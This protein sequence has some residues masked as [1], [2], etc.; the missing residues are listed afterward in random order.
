MASVR[1]IFE[2]KPEELI[3]RKVIGPFGNSEPVQIVR[4]E[5]LLGDPAKVK[6][7]AINPETHQFF[8]PV[9][10]IQKLE[11]IEF[12]T[13]FNFSGDPQRFF[14]IMMGNAI[15]SNFNQDPLF[16]VGSSKID[17]L[18]HQLE[19]VY[20]YILPRPRTRFMIADEPGAGKTIMAGLVIKELLARGAV[21]RI[22]IVV[23]GS[24]TGQ[25][26]L[27][28]K[29][30][31]NEDFVI[32][33]SDFLRSLGPRAWIQFEK[34]ITSMDFAKNEVQ[35]KRQKGMS[36]IRNSLLGVPWDI[37][38]VDEAHKMS[39]EW[40]M[41]QMRERTTK[42]YQLGKALSEQTDHLLFLTAT[43]H[44][45]KSDNFRLLLKLLESDSF[46]EGNM[47]I[48]PVLKEFQDEEYPIFIRR[49]KEEMVTPEGYPIFPPRK[50]K[51]I[52][53][54]LSPLESI[55]YKN[56]TEYVKNT[57]NLAKAV[58]GRRGSSIGFM[59]KLLQR[60]LNSSVRAIHRTLIHRKERLEEI[61][62]NP[63][64]DKSI[65]ELRS[66]IE[67]LSLEVEEAEL[68]DDISPRKVEAIHKEI[69][70][71]TMASNPAELEMEIETLGML[72]QA[73][74]EAET[75]QCESKL[76]ALL[77]EIERNLGEQ[78]LIIFTEYTDTL[79]YLMERIPDVFAKGTIHGGMDYSL[80][81]GEQEKFWNKKIQIL[82]CTD[83]ASE[84]INLQCCWNLINYDIPWNPNRLDQR[85][86]RIHRYLQDHKCTFFNLVATET[87]DGDSIAEGLVVERIF[88]K[89][90]IMREELGGTDRVFDV[91][92][93]IFE[94]WNF[95]QLLVQSLK[96]EPIDFSA[97]VSK[98]ESKKIQKLLELRAN[99]DVGLEFFV[100]Q[101]TESEDN[102]LWP[103]YIAEY[104][105]SGFWYA[106]RPVQFVGDGPFKIQVPPKILAQVKKNVQKFGTIKHNLEITFYKPTE[107][108][109]ME[110]AQECDYVTAG[111]PLLE[112]IIDIAD[113]KGQDAIQQGTIFLDPSHGLH[114]LLWFIEIIFTDGTCSKEILRRT[115][116]LFTPFI[117]SNETINE[118]ISYQI[119]SPLI[120]WDLRRDFSAGTLVQ[121]APYKAFFEHSRQ[122]VVEGIGSQLCI[123]DELELKNW[124]EK[125]KKIK[126]KA[127]ERR[128]IRERVRLEAGISLLLDKEA[129][130][131]D[132]EQ[133][134]LEK[135]ADR[136]NITETIQELKRSIDLECTV[137]RQSPRL[138]SIA[139]VVPAHDDGQPATDIEEATQLADTHAIDVAAMKA[140]IAYEKERGW[141]VKDKSKIKCG[142]DIESV[143]HRDPTEIRHIEVKGHKGE[144]DVFISKN[145]WMKAQNDVSGNYWLYIVNKAL[146]KP[147]VIPISDPASKFEP[148]RII[149]EKF[150]IPLKQIREFY[151]N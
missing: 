57:F 46:D 147:Q 131:E 123:E 12:V 99:V 65:K 39:A 146:E 148:E 25:W 102:R 128:E 40:D 92:G 104:V 44:K 95:E 129:D 16:A 6:F 75:E 33:D 137:I 58:G 72:I 70:C 130:G 36:F 49:L 23:P 47:D 106:N 55:L 134:I 81:A 114:G 124:R 94:E 28:L 143:N 96:V 52:S 53:F 122:F 14:M 136:D 74:A 120:L 145:E 76:N 15:R 30:R 54:S 18:P 135:E 127:L 66:R 45:G 56:V 139:I 50:A 110:N 86:G 69:F 79:D 17:P 116:V 80:R 24:L 13:E 67:K 11:T 34:I 142:Y 140:V 100:Q 98:A 61:L 1:E 125:T 77:G 115:V 149:T 117:D 22:L 4:V 108:Q 35:K 59:L 121:L 82:V 112:A 20:K 2:Q 151:N 88:E 78:Q 42:R 38:V 71:L 9:L 26:R 83:A 64:F 32:L 132:V 43:P 109:L 87:S 93:D 60:R 29:N 111:H 63:D 141:K 144:E 41:R 84:G 5:R 21:K 126:I 133:K 118:K 7:I 27:E 8:D 85:M 48:L 97:Q 90:E 113:K 73:A 91:I 105:R 119:L 3:N 103:K 107:R 150:K 101:R 31:F 62:N 89:L 51:T 19:A 68:N 10:D 37:I 138:L